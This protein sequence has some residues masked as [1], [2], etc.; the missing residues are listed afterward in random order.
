[1]TRRDLSSQDRTRPKTGPSNIFRPRVW[2]CAVC[3][4]LGARP[5]AARIRAMEGIPVRPETI[6]SPPAT[7]V[8]RAEG[9]RLPVD[10]GG[11]EERATAGHQEPR[12]SLQELL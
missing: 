5:V 7:R 11:D 8:E 10:A 6:R 4:E 2:H 1:M 12:P 9:R 3:V